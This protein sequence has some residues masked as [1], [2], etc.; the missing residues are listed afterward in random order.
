VLLSVSVGLF[1]AHGGAFGSSG[2]TIN[3][4]AQIGIVVLIA[5][6]GQERHF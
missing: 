6:C 4:Y 3:I 5:L 1:G 2:L